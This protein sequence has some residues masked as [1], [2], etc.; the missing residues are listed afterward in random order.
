[1]ALGGSKQTAYAK[2]GRNHSSNCREGS[3]RYFNFGNNG[4]FMRE[5][6]KNQKGNCNL[7]NR[8]QF[9]S[10]APPDKAEPRGATSSTGG[11]INR[12]YAINSRQKLEDSP[13][14]VTGMIK[15][16]KLIV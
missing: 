9:F 16:F 8:V 3:T 7:G 10:I 12:L 5:C 1:M 15:D 4:Y 14:I 2:C 11:G 13:D 6:S